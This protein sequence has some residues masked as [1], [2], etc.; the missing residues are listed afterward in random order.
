MKPNLRVSLE[1]YELT[2]R[3]SHGLFCQCFEFYGED[4]DFPPATQLMPGKRQWYSLTHKHTVF[5]PQD[6]YQASTF[7]LETCYLL[8]SSC[9]FLV[10]L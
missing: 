10:E 2:L 6:T 3:S 9:D 1:K 8:I 7:H 5:F 4:F